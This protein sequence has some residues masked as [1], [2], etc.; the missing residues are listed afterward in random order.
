M[1]LDVS[2]VKYLL[3]WGDKETLPRKV[4]F[5]FNRLDQIMNGYEGTPS[6]SRALGAI[7]ILYSRIRR[8]ERAEL[9]KD[10]LAVLE[11]HPDEFSFSNWGIDETFARVIHKLGCAKRAF[12]TMAGVA[13]ANN[14]G[15]EEEFRHLLE[16]LKNLGVA[17]P[18]DEEWTALKPAEK[19]K[20]AP[21]K[22]KKKTK[23]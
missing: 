23:K 15:P 2:V 3:K 14:R 11:T 19:P 18:T 22:G 6:E 13:A 17:L 5:A 21:K 12:K 20:P 9:I 16:E 8:N 1:E 4:R 7:L 10:V